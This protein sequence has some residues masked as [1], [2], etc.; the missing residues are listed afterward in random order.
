MGMITMAFWQG[1]LANHAPRI[2]PPGNEYN[3][4]WK[5]EVQKV[6]RVRTMRFFSDDQSTSVWR[7]NLLPKEFGETSSTTHLWQLQAMNGAC[8]DRLQLFDAFT[9][10]KMSTMM[11]SVRKKIKENSSLLPSMWWTGQACRIIIINKEYIM[12]TTFLLLEVPMLTNRIHWAMTLHV[13]MTSVFQLKTDAMG[14][15]SEL[16]SPLVWL[17]G[18]LPPQL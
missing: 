18:A 14:R 4:R 7:M 17:L 11:I 15:Q 16:R 10:C 6:V 2:S 5:K 12:H 8:R 13:Y 3:S 1:T 9:S